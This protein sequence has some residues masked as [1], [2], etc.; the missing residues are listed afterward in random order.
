[1]TIWTKKTVWEQYRF[2]ILGGAVLA[3]SL[4]S[5]FSYYCYLQREKVIVASDLYDKM[6]MAAKKNDKAEAQNLAEILVNEEAKE[7]YTSLSRLLL[8][9]FAID[10]K[11][12]VKAEQYFK[13]ILKI[14]T[15]GELRAVATT[16]LARLWIEQKK[17]SEA[18]DLLT[19]HEVPAG[20]VA[21]Y[22]EVKGDVYLKQNERDKAKEA[23]KLALKA[24]PKEP[25]LMI[26]LILKY[27]DL[28][29]VME[30]LER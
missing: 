11:N 19:G 9:K 5:S 6:M 17:L 21:L 29:G 8:A 22:E 4:Y 2:W 24:I 7:P 26:R 15:T 18:L 27:I 14:H 25:S 30:G 23:Y 13:D 3:V 28:G 10:E 20:Y 12:N 16:R 1:M